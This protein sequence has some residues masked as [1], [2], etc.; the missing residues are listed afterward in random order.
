MVR[1]REHIY[2][3]DKKKTEGSDRSTSKM[4][5][6]FSSHGHTSKD[7]RIY[8]IEQVFGDEFTLQARE[9]YYINKADTVRKGLNSY[10]T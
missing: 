3:V 2:N 10:R 6:H 9:R 7:M 5:A 1:G 8:A 4:Y